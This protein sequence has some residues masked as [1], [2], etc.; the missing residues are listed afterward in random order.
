MMRRPASALAAVAAIATYL[1]LGWHQHAL[2]GLQYDEV[3]DAVPAM[4][5]L[6]GQT[7]S[8]EG[9]IAVFGRDL[10]L[11]MRAHIGPTSTYWTM[12]AFALTG[13]SVATLRASQLVLGALTL[14]LFWLLARRWFDDGTAA[15]AVVMLAT[16]PPFVWW[17]RAGINW[18]LPLLPL[19][20]AMLLALT[21]WWRTRSAW[22]LIAAAWLCGAGIATKI[23]FVWLLP[24]LALW[25]LIVVGLAGL[26]AVVARH[27]PRVWASAVVA[28]GLGLAP[29]LLHN[30]LDGPVTWR[31]LRQNLRRTRLYGHDNLDVA[32]NLAFVTT[33]FLRAMR[34]GTGAMPSPAGGG[35][36]ALLLLVGL[37]VVAAV[38]VR[39]RD[40][41]RL[42]IGGAPD[43]SDDGI[44]ARLFLLLAVALI[45]PA[46]TVST[47]SIG[48]TYLFILLPFAWLVIAVALVDVARTVARRS[49]AVPVIATAAIA[50]AWLAAASVTFQH[51]AA[52]RTV[53]AYLAAT[54]GTN[55]WSDAVDHL[56]TKLESE[57]RDRHPIA[58]DWGIERSVT[59][60][61]EGRVRMPE[62]FEY[63]PHPSPWFD[64]ETAAS[65]DDPRSLYAFHAPA[66]AAF[67]GR[68]EALESAARARGM[69][70]RLVETLLQ[71][72]AQPNILL[73]VAE[74][75]PGT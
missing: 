21:T 1:A 36:G 40:R 27:P 12:A 24:P 51:L 26:R 9:T 65:L 16:A 13:V 64:G 43:R 72:D 57:Y 53:H 52:N 34:G 60:L 17:S 29:M 11:M 47:S 25:T 33:D 59:F 75:A 31:M 66:F 68:F 20:L 46:S 62:S 37:A 55:V 4:E 71:R 74:P 67:P 73:Y 15:V 69:Q 2:P 48:A 7:P 50:S 8:S 39:H 38:V 18:T 70:L 32:N 30:W 63:R 23:L 5:V 35:A 56:A 58:M 3:A 54:G 44:R 19:A 14:L 45:V 6:H 42:A 22:A 41:L 10:P 28:F 61:T 49:A